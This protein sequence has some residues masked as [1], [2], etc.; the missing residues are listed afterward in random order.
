MLPVLVYVYQPWA[1]PLHSV[2]FTQIGSISYDY[3]KLSF[4]LP[5]YK[6]VVRHETVRLFNASGSLPTNFPLRK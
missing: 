2:E 6:A 1:Y 4:R 3:V 5:S